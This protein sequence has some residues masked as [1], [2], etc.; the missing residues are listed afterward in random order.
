M[1]P[2]NE[3]PRF[4][5]AGGAFGARYSAGFD[6]APGGV[7]RYADSEFGATQPHPPSFQALSL[8]ST[9]PPSVLLGL[10]PSIHTASSSNNEQPE[11][12]G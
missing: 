12:T 4:R 10:E 6:P 3:P 11:A 8:E 2:P 1:L 9:A 7:I 5:A